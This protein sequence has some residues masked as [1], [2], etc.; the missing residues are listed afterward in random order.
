MCVGSV[1]VERAVTV[2]LAGLELLGLRDGDQETSD[3]AGLQRT[4][5][6][7]REALPSNTHCLTEGL[8]F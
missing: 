8:H 1:E 2:G 4:R 7:H 6:E 5:W 3:A